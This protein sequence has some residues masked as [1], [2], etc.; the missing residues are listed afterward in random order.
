MAAKRTNS[1]TKKQQPGDFTRLVALSLLLLLVSGIGVWQLQQWLT[2]PATLPIKTVKID[3]EI[4]YLQKH[5]LEN[6][7]AAL[8]SGG[9]FSIDLSAIRR[10]AQQL[11]WVDDVSIRRHWPDTLVMHI[12]EKTALARWGDSQLVTASGEIFLPP[13]DMPDGLPLLDGPDE[14]ATEVVARFTREAQRFAGLGLELVSLAMNQ[15]GAWTLEFGNG[16]TIAVGRDAF[17]VR[18]A[19]LSRHFN[20]LVEMKGMPKRVDLRYRHGISVQWP[21]APA[22]NPAQDPDQVRAAGQAEGAA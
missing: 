21:A 13:G 18:L 16:L 15:R 19:R 11:A 22:Q 8:V 7:I 9:F 14:Q 3:G 20:R 6:S 2:D 17:E 10:T 1:K 5:E 4:R 12:S